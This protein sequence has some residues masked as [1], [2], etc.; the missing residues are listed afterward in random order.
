MNVFAITSIALLAVHSTWIVYHSFVGKVN[1]VHTLARHRIKERG[2]EVVKISTVG[3]VMASISLWFGNER[4]FSFETYCT[5][6]FGIII[7]LI[8]NWTTHTFIKDM[9]SVDDHMETQIKVWEAMIEDPNTSDSKKE[10][11]KNLIE[12]YSDEKVKK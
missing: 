3:L 11:A 12:I 8:I 7:A 2:F 6:F 10:F 9:L 1:L 5:L 4:G